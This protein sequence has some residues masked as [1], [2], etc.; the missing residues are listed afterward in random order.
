MRKLFTL[1]A[2]VLA[3]FSL[4]AVVPTATLDPTDVPTEGWAGKYAPAFI[5]NGDWVC[6]SPYEIYQSGSQTWA[7][8][9]NGGSTD[10]SWDAT[11]P[12]PAQ[13]AWTTNDGKV[14]T[15][16]Q[17]QKGP[18]YYRIT[19]TTDVAALV[20]SGSNKKRTIFLEAYELTNGEAPATPTKSISMESSTMAVIAL[21]ELD[22][23]KE[24]MIVVRAEDTGTGG[25]SAGNSNYY[26]IGFK[27]VTK[28]I[29]ST[30][31]SLTAVTINDVA[32]S[33]TDLASLVSNKYLFLADAYVTAPVVK[34][35]KHTVIT[36]DDSST[37]EKDEVI[38]VTSQPATTTWG[39]SATI[40]GNSYYVYTS[41]AASRTVTYMYGEQVLG[42]EIVA[43]NG[44][45][46]EY[47]QYETMPLA[48][49]GGWYKD[50][51]LTQKVESMA[52]EVISADVTFYAKFSKAYAQ[53]IDFEGM[54]INNGKSYDVKSA[55]TA[56]FY[57][58]KTIDA[59]DSLNNEKGAGRNEPY[60]GLKIKKQGGYLA[61]NVVP[62]TTIRI[63]FGYVAETVLA[64]AGNDTMELKP[65]DNKIAALQFPIAVEKLVKLQTTSDKTVVIKQIMIDEPLVTWM[66]PITYAPAENGKVEGWTIA[67]PDETVELTVTPDEGYKAVSVT[68]G[69]EAVVPVEGAYSFVMP[70]TPVTVSATFDV[71]TAIENTAAETKVVKRVVN[72]QLFIE[73]AG[74]LYNAQGAVVK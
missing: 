52:A 66:Y 64:I 31:E 33:A 25:S 68:A 62:G 1:A 45:P 63:K 24:Y 29:V 26:A 16:R 47:A 60:L 8:K 11:D 53:S 73:K 46:A 5:V 35:T 21:N 37:K 40:N 70:A 67:F 27:A 51:E 32:I 4:W 34:F 9:D 2:A 28:T 22:A 69:N 61:C 71:A 19:N 20:K 38:E 15:V 36:Y 3:S 23:T 42:T 49:F 12:F 59:L 13:S 7:A 57:D 48:T 6:F 17:G 39:A 50:A 65:T 58:Y 14:A 55:L 56:N 41:K 43:A 18:Y 44:N 54:V 72:G 74:V 30:E 10:G